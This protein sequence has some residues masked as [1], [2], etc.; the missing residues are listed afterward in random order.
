VVF[1]ESRNVKCLAAPD[2]V[3]VRISEKWHERIDIHVSE[4]DLRACAE[5]SNRING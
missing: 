4:I 2:V 5:A 3:T 1:D